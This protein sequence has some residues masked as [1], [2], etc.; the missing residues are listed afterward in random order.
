[1]G[2]HHLTAPGWQGEGEYRF[3]FYEGQVYGL[4]NT[5][6]SLF[7]LLVVVSMIK[8]ILFGSKMKAHL[9]RESFGRIM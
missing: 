4:E 6:I 3:A 2:I 1:M 7:F 9:S 8:K 5:L